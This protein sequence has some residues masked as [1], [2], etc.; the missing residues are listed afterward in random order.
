MLQTYKFDFGLGKFELS[1]VV[2]NVFAWGDRPSQ[3]SKGFELRNKAFVKAK[4]TVSRI[5]SKQGFLCWHL[6]SH[7]LLVHLLPFLEGFKLLKGDLH[8]I[9]I[10][11]VAFNELAMLFRQVL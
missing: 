11:Y 1:L 9:L 2:L 3:W 5:K 10:V 6:K 8:V 4:R 7:S